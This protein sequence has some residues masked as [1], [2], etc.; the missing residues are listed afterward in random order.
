MKE[1]RLNLARHDTP[2][3]QVELEMAIDRACLN[4]AAAESFS[5]GADGSVLYW[6]SGSY[7]A[8]EMQ[9]L[10]DDIVRVECALAR[11]QR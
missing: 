3:V 6:M 7:S 11:I 2:D 9:S 5:L 1:K 4:V 8:N 10:L